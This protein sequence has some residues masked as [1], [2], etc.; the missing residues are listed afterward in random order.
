MGKILFKKNFEGIEKITDISNPIYIE[1]QY[2]GFTDNNYPYDSNQLKNLLL[3]K[4]INLISINEDSRYYSD[5]SH[6]LVEDVQHQEEKIAK[7]E[8]KKQYEEMLKQIQQRKEEKL[9]K[10]EIEKE[11]EIKKAE[12][13]KKV[14][15]VKIVTGEDISKS[16][17]E[18]L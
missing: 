12:K 10:Q 8:A 13:N 17:T 4:R 3:N 11:K 2:F 5:L 16:I 9:R 14:K 1:H 18:N 15:K 6:F 7:E